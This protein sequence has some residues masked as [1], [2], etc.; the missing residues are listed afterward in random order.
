MA[1]DN[2]KKEK[3]AEV[4]SLKTQDEKLRVEMEKLA[5][6]V[7]RLRDVSYTHG[8]VVGAVPGLLDTLSALV[9]NQQAI[10]ARL[11]ALQRIQESYPVVVGQI[12][13]T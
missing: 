5:T 6:D 13:L 7:G 8:T 9:T 3:N 11:N 12:L 2:S 4:A 1:L 10:I